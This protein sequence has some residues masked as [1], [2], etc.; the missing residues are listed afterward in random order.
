M[1][2]AERI[3]RA[4]EK[5]GPMDVPTL[6]SLIDAEHI[7]TTCS[8][9]HRKKKLVKLGGGPKTTIYGLP[10]QKAPAGGA[11]ATPARKIAR[12]SR[13]K[14]AKAGLRARQPR[15]GAVTLG[16]SDS[17]LQALLADALSGRAFQLSIEETRELAAAAYLPEGRA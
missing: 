8:Q 14:P 16:F 11:E 7:A 4:I 3:L 1:T 9:L 10:G 2:T 17:R 13:T 6:R 5:R 12:K 15:L